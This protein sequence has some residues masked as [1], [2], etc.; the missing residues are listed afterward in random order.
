MANVTEREPKIVVD[1]FGGQHFQTPEEVEE[2]ERWS[3]MIDQL[4]DE[5]EA[6]RLAEDARAAEFEANGGYY[7][8]E[9]VEMPW[10]C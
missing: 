6:L 2:Y 4:N 3:D 1:P 5:A 10:E 8:D 7:D 9:P